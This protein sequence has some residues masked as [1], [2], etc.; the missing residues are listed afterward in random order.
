MKRLIALFVAV[1]FP[2]PN[3]MAG[4]PTV[5]AHTPR[6]PLAPGQ[7]STQASLPITTD[8]HLCLYL[9]TAI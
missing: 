6:P 7:T 9:N 4:Y 2:T 8:G 5:C 1:L 3:G